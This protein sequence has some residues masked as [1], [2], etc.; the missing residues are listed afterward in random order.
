MGLP[1]SIML[2]DRA[3]HPNLRNFAGNLQCFWQ[4]VESPERQASSYIVAF[5]SVSLDKTRIDPSRCTTDCLSLNE[6][7]RFQRD[8]ACLRGQSI[9]CGAPSTRSGRKT[10]TCYP[11]TR[12]HAST[13]IVFNLGSSSVP[14]IDVRNGQL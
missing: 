10:C 4:E 5:S 8:K 3:Q 6:H 2:A 7:V 1:A 13:S 12:L 14:A 9:Q 11:P